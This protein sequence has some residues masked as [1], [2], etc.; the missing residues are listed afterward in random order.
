[1]DAQL[2][3]VNSLVLMFV[4]FFFARMSDSI[5]FKYPSFIFWVLTII[6]FIAM[7]ISLVVLLIMRLFSLA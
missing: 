3:L 6:S 5:G 4:F 2:I 7:A 1:M